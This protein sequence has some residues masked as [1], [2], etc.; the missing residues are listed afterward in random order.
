[1]SVVNVVATVR[2]REES[3]EEFEAVVARTRPAMLADPGCLRYDLQRRRNEP[4]TYV[5]LEAYDST[6]AL[7]RH[8]ASPEFAEFGKALASLV[9]GEPEVVLLTPVGEQTA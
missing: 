7:R 6:D 4:G 2:V 1:M 8:G 9:T 3:I 5:L